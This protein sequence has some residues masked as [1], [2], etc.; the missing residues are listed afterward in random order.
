MI[1]QIRSYASGRLLVGDVRTCCAWFNTPCEQ[2]GS[3]V[4]QVT[5]TLVFMTP[6]VIEDLRVT[7]GLVD[8]PEVIRASG[9]PR[10]VLRTAMDDGWIVPT[11]VRRGTGRGRTQ[12]LTVEDALFVLAVAALAVAAG[13]AFVTLMKTLKTTGAQLGPDGIKI[14]LPTAT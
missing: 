3:R 10:H 7:D 1:M 9:L 13:V 4:I 11:S 2:E 5:A 8:F 6:N 12:T 14:P